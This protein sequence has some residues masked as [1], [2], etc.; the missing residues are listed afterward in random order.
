MS[1]MWQTLLADKKKSQILNDTM[2][3]QLQDFLLRVLD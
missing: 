3:E 2:Y 1:I